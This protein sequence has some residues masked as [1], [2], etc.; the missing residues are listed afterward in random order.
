MIIAASNKDICLKNQ[1]I[2]SWK[3]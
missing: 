2:T 3:T 1:D